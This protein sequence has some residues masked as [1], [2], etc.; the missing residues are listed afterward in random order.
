MKESKVGGRIAVYVPGHPHANNRGY[1]LRYRYNMEQKL[2]RYLEP[3]ENVH[4][5]NGDCEDD[6]PENLE[7]MTRGAHTALHNPG[8]KRKCR[9]DREKVQ[10]LY[11][12]GLGCRR[13]AAVLGC[14]TTHAK[15]LT[16]GLSSR[17]C[18]PWARTRIDCETTN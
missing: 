6:S 2:G 11:F 4:H 16:R 8:A 9:V 13:I 14:S 12:Q 18:I 15:R 17:P 5:L 10:Q 7:L 3:N 1:V